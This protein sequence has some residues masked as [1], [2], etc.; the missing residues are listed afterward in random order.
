MENIYVK[1]GFVIELKW[2]LVFY[3][4]VLKGVDFVV[5]IVK[6]INYFY[7]LVSKIVKEMKVCDLIESY[8]L[9]DDLWVMLVV[10]NDKVKVMVFKMEK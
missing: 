9:S 4:F 2:F 6:E 8:K 1:F 10:L 7:V 3:V 5:N